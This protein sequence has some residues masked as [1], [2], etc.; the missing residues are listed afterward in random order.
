MLLSNS[1]NFTLIA[2]AASSVADLREAPRCL[3]LREDDRRHGDV[4]PRK[5]ELRK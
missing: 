5:N 2:C 3:I 1:T 4:F